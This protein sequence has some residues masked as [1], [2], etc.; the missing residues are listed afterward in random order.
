M[1]THW[2]TLRV[3]GGSLLARG[4]FEYEE[5]KRQREKAKAPDLEVSAPILAD[6]EQE[7]LARAHLFMP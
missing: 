4:P 1:K 7:A 5:C 3:K 6:T 2:F